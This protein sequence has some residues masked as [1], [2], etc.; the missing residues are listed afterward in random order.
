MAVAPKGCSILQALFHPLSREH[1]CVLYDNGTLVLYKFDFGA[2]EQD[3]GFAPE[4]TITVPRDVRGFC[5][6]ERSGWGC[7]GIYLV[8]HDGAVHAVC[9]VVPYN[10]PVAVAQLSALVELVHALPI[11]VREE[12]QSW[13]E[14]LQLISATGEVTLEQISVTARSTQPSWLMVC[15]DAANEF[16]VLRNPHCDHLRAEVCPTIIQLKPGQVQS[17]FSSEAACAVD[18]L[19]PH[20][21]CRGILCLETS[22]DTSQQLTVV[23]PLAIGV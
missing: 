18:K 4:Q 12:A 23:C 14:A 17:V 7:V 16:A 1:L 3:K 10:T 19:G 20:T 21:Q 13:L 5:F 22:T 6:A 2:R 11:P 9:P 15:Q 8:A